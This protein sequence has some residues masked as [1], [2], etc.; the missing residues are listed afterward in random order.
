MGGPRA[1]AGRLAT[2]LSQSGRPPCFAS[3][4]WAH[5]DFTSPRAKIEA[6]KLSTSVAETS[7]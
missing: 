3:R 5:Q 1:P 7:S 4:R 6:T 2:P